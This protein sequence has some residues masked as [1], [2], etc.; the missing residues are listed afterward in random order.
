MSCRAAAAA[1]AGAGRRAAAPPAA[2]CAGRQCSCPRPTRQPHQLARDVRA[3]RRH[4]EPFD[5]ALRSNKRGAHV[6]LF[7][8]L[9]VCLLCDHL[10][11]CLSRL[12]HGGRGGGACWFLTTVFG[13][14]R[15]PPSVPTCIVRMY[16]RLDRADD[17]LAYGCI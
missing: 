1:E 13:A 3:V 8:H 11:G 6:L 12:R 17:S 7:H 15:R 2:A 10:P 16:E 5:G 9:S 14:A 4:F